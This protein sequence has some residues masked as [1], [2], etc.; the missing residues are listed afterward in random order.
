VVFHAG[1]AEKEGRVVTSGGRVLGVTSHAPKLA[2]AIR[3]AYA[4]CETIQFEGVFFRRDIGKK[5]LDRETR[6]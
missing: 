3:Q 2:D 5:A 4:A 6:K 1:T